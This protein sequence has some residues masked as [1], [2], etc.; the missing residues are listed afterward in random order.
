MLKK[1]I[2]WNQNHNT[3]KMLFTKIIEN[4]RNAFTYEP[5]KKKEKREQ[6]KEKKVILQKKH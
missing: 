4:K 6:S 1:G 2:N 3:H 5:K